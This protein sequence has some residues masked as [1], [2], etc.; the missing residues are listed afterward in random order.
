MLGLRGIRLSLR[1]PAL[2]RTQLRAILRAAAH[3]NV[4]I[5]LPLVSGLEQVRAARG[6]VADVA[7]ELAVEGL[8]HDASV[9]LGAMIEVPSAALL[10]DRL[11]RTVDFFSIGTND[12][13]QYTLAVDRGNEQLSDLYEP[14]HPAVLTMLWRTVEGARGAGIPVA[15]CGEMAGSLRYLPLL[16][17]LGL[18]ELSMTPPAVPRVKR[19]LR[20]LRRDACEALVASAIACETA[21]DVA[22]LLDAARPDE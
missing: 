8:P 1:L 12:L 9:P 22:A 2:L 19:A 15:M 14:L 16:V 17:G 21:A 7:R 6:I 3:G 20:T 10:A 13:I 18:A 11:A 4:R 5:L